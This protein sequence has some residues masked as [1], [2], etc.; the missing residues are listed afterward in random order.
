MHAGELKN[1]LKKKKR[2]K[3]KTCG[4]FFVV[5]VQEFSEQYAAT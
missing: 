2:C 3:K 1:C 4:Q 5:A